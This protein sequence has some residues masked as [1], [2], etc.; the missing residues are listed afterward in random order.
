[1]SVDLNSLLSAL[2]AITGALASVYQW[3]N[4][5]LRKR[6]KDD[7]EILKS[8]ESIDSRNENYC[9]VSRYIDYTITK[10]YACGHLTDKGRASFSGKRHINVIDLRLG[11]LFGV[12][13]LLWIAEILWVGLTWWRILIATAFAIVGFVAFFNVLHKRSASLGVTRAMCGSE[14]H[15]K[16]S[17]SVEE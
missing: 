2:T 1:M 17:K 7:L 5:R 8:L 13:S 9:M 4:T 15:Q 10:A 16:R 12:V 14:F 11:I 6:L 3:W